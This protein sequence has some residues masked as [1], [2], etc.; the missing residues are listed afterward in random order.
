MDYFAWPDEVDTIVLPE[1]EVDIKRSLSAEDMDKIEDH[2]I[3]VRLKPSALDKGEVNFEEI[4]I[5]SSK[6]LLLQLCIKAWRGPGFVKNGEAV[7]VTPENIAVLSAS[8]RNLLLSEINARNK[9]LK[10]A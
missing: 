10:K 6:Q 4:E 8:V 2:M 7:P 9:E 3:K 1:G 5:K